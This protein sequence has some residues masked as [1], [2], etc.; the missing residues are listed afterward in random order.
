MYDSDFYDYQNEDAVGEMNYEQS[1]EDPLIH[2]FSLKDGG[3]IPLLKMTYINKTTPKPCDKE[4][5]LYEL[6][7]ERL[8]HPNKETGKPTPVKGN[9]NNCHESNCER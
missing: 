9:L 7:D 2:E 1:T 3:R 6:N 4:V 8:Y 5:I